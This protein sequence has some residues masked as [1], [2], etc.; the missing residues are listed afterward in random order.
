MASYWCLNPDAWLPL[1]YSIMI[2]SKP[3]TNACTACVWVHVHWTDHYCNCYNVSRGTWCASERVSTDVAMNLLTMRDC[4]K[5]RR[6]LHYQLQC[7]H[8]RLRAQEQ[9][10]TVLRM[11]LSAELHCSVH[12]YSYC[13]YTVLWVPLA[14]F[15]IS[16]LTLV[17][18]DTSSCMVNSIII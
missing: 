4:V 10:F 7:W 11:Y 13:M 15:V 12:L 1:C 17:W 14:H 9:S 8:G 2:F 16:S 6:K 3:H 18:S 5:Q